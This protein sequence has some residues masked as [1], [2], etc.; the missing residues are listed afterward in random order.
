M[1]IVHL[2]TSW[3]PINELDGALGLDGG[4][5]SIDILGHDITAVQH[6][7]SHVLAVTRVALRHHRGRLEHGVGDFRDGELLVV[8]LLSRDDGGKHEVD[9]WVGHQVGL[10][11]SHVYVQSAIETQRSSEGADDLGNQTVQVG[12]GG[13]MSS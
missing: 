10:E 1:K 5:S 13:S 6:A 9:T 2:E 7:A 11:L 3:A 8:G 12:V 4:N